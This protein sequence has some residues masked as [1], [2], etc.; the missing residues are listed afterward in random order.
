MNVG[1]DL[2][3]NVHIDPLDGL[4]MDDYDF[5]CLFY[6]SSLIKS[7]KIK[8][9]KMIRI[10]SQNYVAVVCSSKTGPGNLKLK[11]TACIPDDS[12]EIH[13]GIRIEVKQIDTGIIIEK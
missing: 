12:V 2:K 1:T 7:V 5:E 13:D 9:E 10:D 4:T 6:T 11:V 3:I 8:K